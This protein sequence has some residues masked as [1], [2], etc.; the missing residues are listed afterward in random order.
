MTKIKYLSIYIT[1]F[2][3]VCMITLMS[4]AYQMDNSA[5]ASARDFS[6]YKN[7]LVI[8][9]DHELNYQH[10]T[11]NDTYGIQRPNYDE[12]VSSGVEF[13]NAKSVNPLCS[14][15]RRSLLTGLYPHQHG[16]IHNSVNVPV[17]P[18]VDTIY[19]VLLEN[20]FP[21]DNAYFYGKTHYSGSSMDKDTP[22]YSY[23]INGWST[24]G[25]GQPYKTQEYKDYLARNNYFGSDYRSPVMVIEEDSLSPNGRPAKGETFDVAN[26]GII[27]GNIFGI[28]QAPKEFHEAFFL[29]DMV[30]TEL[31]SIAKSNSDEPFVMSVNIWGPHHPY[32]PTQE[33]V[34]LYTDE[35]GVIGGNIEEY[36]SFNDPFINKP[37]VYAWDNSE[38][39]TDNPSLPTPNEKDWETFR[40][41]M[42][43]A[44]AQTTMVDEAV[45][46]ILDTLDE[47]G[48][49]DD[50][51]VIW[52]NDHG[53]ALGAHGGH[54]DKECYM[55]EEILDIQLAVRDPSRPDLAGTKNTA[56]VNTNDVPVTM[57]DAMGLSFDYEV[58]GMSLLDLMYGE[59]APRQY[60]V[61][62]TNG[63]F[64][65]TRARTV[66]FGDYKYTY[67]TNDIDELYNL[68]EDPFEMT[69]LIFEKDKQG[70]INLMKNMLYNWQIEQRDNIPLINI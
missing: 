70:I 64:S 17:Y 57:L 7:V 43:L 24:P 25:Y 33:Y 69:N 40:T 16:I 19:D 34:D 42:A 21:K 68:K 44:Y 47:T 14:P 50:T 52:T 22:Q 67:Y 28:M 35:N 26:M 61:C 4:F 39:G 12:F 5:I 59:V 48:L 2:L 65:D 20:S 6:S 37:K 51:L 49:A 23:G 41:Y 13:V 55:I 36:P 18:N 9:T 46:T 45:G 11:A 30:N 3:L 32:Y 60:M 53:D 8:V 54:A 31:K 66:Y 56:L 29:A 27:T 62:T 38:K 15:A 10:G 1:S 58:P 63:H